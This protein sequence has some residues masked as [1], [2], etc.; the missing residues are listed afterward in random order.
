VFGLFPGKTKVIVTHD[1]ELMKR[2]DQ[3]VLLSGGAVLGCGTYEELKA[4]CEH[5]QE[6]LSACEGEV[7]VQ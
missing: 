3:V 5:F 7:D 1:P 4:G 6:L 2:A